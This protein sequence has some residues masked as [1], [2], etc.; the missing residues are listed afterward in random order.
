MQAFALESRFSSPSSSLSIYLWSFLL[1]LVT[2]SISVVKVEGSYFSV[3][4]TGSGCA[5]IACY[6]QF[7]DDVNQI[8]HI[9]PVYRE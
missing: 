2:S 8:V 4:M 6:A 9:N 1:L 3:C 7:G 5:I